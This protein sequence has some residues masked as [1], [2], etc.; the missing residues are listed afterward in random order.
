MCKFINENDELKYIILYK[1]INYLFF[2]DNLTKIQFYNE[3]YETYDLKS[4]F[5]SNINTTLIKITDT[6][7]YK[8]SIINNTVNI[9]GDQ[10][11]YDI[12]EN[13]ANDEIL[14]DNKFKNI[15]ILNKLYYNYFDYNEY[16]NIF[17]INSNINYLEKKL[18]K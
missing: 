14:K 1:N 11:N 4:I 18:F 5:Y 12:L 13:V 10:I 15:S 6:K 7:K 8:W 3:V 16:K 17:K 9:Q 2:I